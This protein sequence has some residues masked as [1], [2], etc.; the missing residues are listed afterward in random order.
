MSPG[1]AFEESISDLDTALD[2]LDAARRTARKLPF[3]N[4][5][6]GSSITSRFGNRTDPFLG[7]L[8]LHAGIDFRAATGTEVH[9][10]GA[11]TVTVAGRTGG[12]GNMVEID[13]GNGLT[14]RYAHLTRVLVKIG[15]RVEASDPVGLSG[16]TGRSTGPHVHYEVRR[17]GKAVDP[18]RFL[19]AGMKLTTYMD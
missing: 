18:M 19:T 16:T 4:P 6:P 5:A 15:D 3:G 17:N 14:T 1:D 9:C 11:G 10:T 12:Y 13:H 2:R 7:R 8:A